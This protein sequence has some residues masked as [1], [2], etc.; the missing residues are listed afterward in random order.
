MRITNNMVTN[1]MMTELQNLSSTQSQLQTEISTGLAVTQPSD[2][3]AAFGQVVSMESQSSQL[4]QFSD[5]ASRALDLAN[6]SYSGL[7][8]MNTIYDRATQ[9][10]TLGTSTDGTTSDT[11]YASELDQLIQ[12]TV[13]TA[14]SEEGGQYLYGGTATNTPPF[15]TT[16]DA[17]GTITGVTYVGN[18]SQTSIPISTT[19]SVTVGTSGATNQGI[20]TMINHMIALRDALNSGDTTALATANT[21]LA[22]DDDTL[23]DAVAENGA[24][25]SRIE[26]E[27]TQQQAETTEL[28]TQISDAT[29]ADLPTTEVKLNQAQL[30][31]QAALQTAAS[32]MH[33]SILN[34][35]T[36][37]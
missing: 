22:G 3:P 11:D 18:T 29:S 4:A 9:L 31:Y 23:T 5:N 14:N 7:S 6:S 13:S 1:T 32:V 21:N 17:N 26:S 27:Q 24:V 8:S 19:S 34:Y 37:S 12:Q 10:G 15:T 28:S 25:Q 36:L 33:M 30:A 16:T 2:D 35:I 20:A